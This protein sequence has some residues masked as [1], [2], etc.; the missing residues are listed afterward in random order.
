MFAV[1]LLRDH[2]QASPSGR[3]LAER[4]APVSSLEP[5]CRIAP[6][7]TRSTSRPQACAY[8]PA[9]TVVTSTPKGLD[10]GDERCGRTVAV[11][12]DGAGAVFLR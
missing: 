5:R 11:A 7:S 2:A 12:N 8:S 6:S 10:S 1:E 9:V 3:V 4:M